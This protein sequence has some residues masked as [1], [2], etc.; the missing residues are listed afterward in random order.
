MKKDEIKQLLMN[1]RTSDN[2]PAV[3]Y[4]LGS[5]DMMSDEEIY[6]KMKQL[7]INEENIEQFL[8]SKVMQIQMQN[9]EPE[10]F[11]GVNKMF[12][13]GR[14]GD[15]IHMHLIPKDLRN[16]KK[17]LGDEA[18][19]QFY[20]DQL[21]D[22][23]SRLQDIFRN[24]TSMKTLFAVSPIF[25]NS[26]ISMAHENL[27]FDT[28]TEIDTENNSDEISKEQKQYFLDMFNQNKDHKKRVYYTSISREKLLETVY[29]RIPEDEK[30][31]LDD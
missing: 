13:Y 26:N 5:I 24:D 30:T 10:H 20:Q 27:G 19:Y 22:F 16:L 18:F 23:L 29:T 6:A 1:M 11:I 28:I 2:E 7:N 21:E 12:C 8:A 14:T 4:L 3:N 15:T 25:F 31:M 9:D 17:Q